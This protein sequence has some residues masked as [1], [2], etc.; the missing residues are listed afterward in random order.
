MHEHRA[1]QS[2]LFM[3]IVDLHSIVLA[4]ITLQI[5]FEY[6]DRYS[7]PFFSLDEVNNG[8]EGCL[9][10]IRILYVRV[11]HKE[12]GVDNKVFLL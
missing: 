4:L 2:G 12:L 10:F 9:E 7:V 6:D 5:Y 3:L 8:L 1:S 11:T